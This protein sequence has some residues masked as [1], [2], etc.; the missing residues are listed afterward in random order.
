[1]VRNFAVPELYEMS[2][3]TLRE[4]VYYLGVPDVIHLQMTR[5]Q[6]AEAIVDITQRTRWH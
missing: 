6:L 1:M 2:L 4:W 5:K 3:E